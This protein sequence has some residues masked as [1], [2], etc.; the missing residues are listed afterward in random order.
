MVYKNKGG[1]SRE[2][3]MIA[4]YSLVRDFGANQQAVANTLNCSQSTIA[5]WVKEGDQ[6][7]KLQG[8]EREL[9]EA[10]DYI[11]E[12]HAEINNDNLLAHDQSEEGGEEN[13]V[14]DYGYEDDEDNFEHAL[15][16]I[17]K[18]NGM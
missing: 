10:K 15:D 11:Q 1:Q 12:L 16:D 9:A 6:Q 4:A 13:Y 14:P 5:N 18:A 8:L 3:T 7:V 17:H 2:K